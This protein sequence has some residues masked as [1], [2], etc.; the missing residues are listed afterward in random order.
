M[1]KIMLTLLGAVLLTACATSGPQPATWQQVDLTEKTGARLTVLGLS[2]PL[3]SNNLDGQLKK[4]DAVE[5]ATIDLETGAVT[6][7]FNAAGAV[8]PDALAEAVKHAGFTLKTVE[9]LP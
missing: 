2:C 7:R 5:S 3:C 1:Q 6:V 9:P 4:I 8:T